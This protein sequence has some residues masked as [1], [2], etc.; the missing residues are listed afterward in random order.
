[1]LDIKSKTNDHKTVRS[2]LLQWLAT[3]AIASFAYFLLL[4]L[5]IIFSDITRVLLQIFLPDVLYRAD[6]MS[7]IVTIYILMFIAITVGF[8]IKAALYLEKC[9]AALADIQG[10]ASG[11]HKLPKTMQETENIIRNIYTQLASKERAANEAEQRKNDLILYIAH[12]LKTPLTSI[13]GYLTILKES[14]ELPLEYRAKYT[15]ITLSKAYRLEQL[16][17]EFFDITRF[18]L[19]NIELENNRIN[20]SLLL[21]QLTDEFY[22]MLSSKSLTLSTDIPDGISIIGDSDKLVRVFDNLLKNA[23]SYS[24]PGTEIT[25]KAGCGADIAQIR[26]RNTGDEIPEEK[27]PRIFEKFF[28]TD[29]SRGTADGGAGLGLAI[30]KEIVELHG[31][32]ISAVSSQKYTEFTVL[33]PVNKASGN[34]KKTENMH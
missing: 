15:G 9:N 7:F 12:D 1:M 31:G 14:P 33:L 19:H 26:V 30:A 2:F 16:I 20:L 21:S 27:L 32:K 22:P 34:I 18:N 11:S 28:R 6:G 29:E 25:I 4:T 8:M 24:Y 13:I 3:E 10:V 23:V 17:N 5:A